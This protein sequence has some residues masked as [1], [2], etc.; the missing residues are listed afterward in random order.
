MQKKNVFVVGMDEFNEKKLNSLEL[1]KT[2]DFRPLLTQEETKGGGTYPLPELMEK[3]E[4]ILDH[5]DGSIDA[6]VG[7]W[8][9]PVTSMVPLLCRKRGLRSASVDAVLKCEHKYWSRQQQSQVISDIPRF[10]AVDPWDEKA[11]DKIDLE[12]PFWVKPVKSFSSHL[13]FKI[14]S[15]EE[16][17][18]AMRA[19]REHIG[20]I[21]K[22]FNWFIEQSE[23]HEEFEKVDGW[24]CIAEEPISGDQCTLEGYVIDGEIHNHGLIDSMNYPGSSVFHRYQ[25]PSKLPDEIK[26]RM[27]EDARKVLQHIGYDNQT[28]NIEFFYDQQQDRLRLLEINQRISQSHAEIFERVDGA[29]NHQVLV[30]VGLGRHP[31]FPQGQGKYPMAAK[32][33]LRRFENGRVSHSPTPE[34]LKKVHQEV[35][36]VVVEVHAEKGMQLSDLLE[37]DSYSYVLAEVYLGGEDEDE[38]LHNYARVVDM[39]DFEF[40]G[41]N[42]HHYWDLITAE[43]LDRSVASQGLPPSA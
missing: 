35:P 38:I 9:F 11:F 28:Y 32:C 18:R 25:Y 39:L 41:S 14:D 43:Q 4:D 12:F 27:V 2:H 42:Q 3:A 29:S 24:Y 1:A 17:E 26:E 16:F 15:R 21:A 40:E 36:G 30:E 22:P 33:F 10:F 37:Q 7:F 34:D 23:N 31:D 5:F 20:F 6:I 19:T 13:A 8:D